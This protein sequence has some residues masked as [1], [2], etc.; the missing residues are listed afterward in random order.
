M[1]KQMVFPNGFLWGGAIAANQVEGAWDVDGKGMSVADVAKLKPNIAVSDYKNQWHVGSKDIKEAMATV[2]PLY[3]PKRR[4]IDFYHHYEE[5]IKLFAE[6]GFKVLRLSIAWTRIFPNGVETEPNQAG[7][8]FYRR[9]FETLKKYHIEPVV[10]LSHYEMPLYLVNHYDGWV[11]RDVI[12]FFVRFSKVVFNEYKDLVKYW[13][14]FNEIDSVF[15][16]PFTT[17]GVVEDK[18]ENQDRLDEAIYQAVHNQFVASALATKYLREISPDAKMGAM[19]TKTQT[20]PETCNPKDVLLASQANRKNYFYS[21]VQVRGE[22]PSYIL[23]EFKDR[24]LN[25]DFGDN[26]LEVLKKNTVDYLSLS[27]YMSRVVSVDMDSKEITGGNLTSGIKN[28]YLET[29]D[30][31]WQIDPIGLRIG[32]VDLYDRYQIPLFIVENGLGAKDHLKADGTIEDDYRIDYFRSHIEQMYEAIQEGVELMGYT[33]WGCID[34]ISASTSQMDKRYG[35]IYV[36]ADD[37]GQGS[38]QRIPKKSFYWYKD[39]I[40][41][42]GASL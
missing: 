9:V 39:I 1:Q 34:L 20:Y 37:F 16:H 12:D 36:D 22:Y 28:P 23:K 42:N 30:W 18:Y 10:T 3:Y 35:F 6:M 7:L 32:L 15:R 25:V 33:P 27:Y 21:D 24:G 17:I 5:D 14:S 4:G 13:I 8:N 38:Y 31:G 19:I 2:D 29:S 26:D 40:E 41:S 11:S